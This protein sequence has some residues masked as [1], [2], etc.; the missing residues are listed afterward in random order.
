VSPPT[1]KE[2]VEEALTMLGKDFTVPQVSDIIK[3]L[4]PRCSLT[5]CEIQSFL[6]QIKGIDSESSKVL[7]F[8]GMK[9]GNHYIKE[10]RGA[11]NHK[12]LEGSK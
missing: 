2:L 6:R 10:D 12:L 5:S 9:R 3:E 7:R 1:K 8:D 11:I 4:H